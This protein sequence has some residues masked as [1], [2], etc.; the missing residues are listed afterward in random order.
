[1]AYVNPGDSIR[2]SSTAHG[3]RGRCPL[4]AVQLNIEILQLDRH[5][6]RHVRMS[7]LLPP[8]LMTKEEEAEARGRMMRV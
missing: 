8:P 2:A 7:V 3:R 5:E 4:P 1:M 6:Q